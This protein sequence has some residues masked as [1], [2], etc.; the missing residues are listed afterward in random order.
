[1][2]RSKLPAYGV[3]IA[4]LYVLLY[5]FDQ[6]AAEICRRGGGWLMFPVMVAFVLSGFHGSL[7]GPS[8]DAATL[9][10][11]DLGAGGA[12]LLKSVG[13]PVGAAAL[14]GG[15]EVMLAAPAGGMRAPARETQ[16]A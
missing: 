14:A 7:T 3:V 8:R 16:P 10:H 5:A 12:A 9:N 1:M 4:A 2:K 6:E 13:V 15:T 11:V